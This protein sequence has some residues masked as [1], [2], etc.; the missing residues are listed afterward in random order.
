MFDTEHIFHHGDRISSAVYLVSAYI[1]YAMTRDQERRRSPIRWNLWINRGLRKKRPSILQPL[2]PPP[3]LSAMLMCG[4]LHY[5]MTNP[6]PLRTHQHCIRG[7]GGGDGCNIDGRFLRR[8]RTL[9]CASK[10]SWRP[11]GC[12]LLSGNHLIRILVL[13]ERASFL[14]SCLMGFRR[15]MNISLRPRLANVASVW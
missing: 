6:R 7:E 14:V 10:W 15:F 12:W 8:P 13:M 3:P 9:C 11:I 2:P 5:C 1:T 4:A